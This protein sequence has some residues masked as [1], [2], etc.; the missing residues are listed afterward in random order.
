MHNDADENVKVVT[1]PVENVI[2]STSTTIDDMAKLAREGSRQ[3]QALTTS[4][5]CEILT[6]IAVGIEAEM[7]SILAA[8]HL[9]VECAQLG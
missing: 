9:D 6:K 8:N 4:Q 7:E 5:R 2:D 1:Q 3:L